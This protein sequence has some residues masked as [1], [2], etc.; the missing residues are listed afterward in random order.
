[1]NFLKKADSQIQR[2]DQC[3]PMWSGAIKGWESGW[4]NQW[5]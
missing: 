4:Y 3:L 2:T 1:M 5:G